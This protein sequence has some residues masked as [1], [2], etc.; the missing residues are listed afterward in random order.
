MLAGVRGDKV[1][2]AGN[3]GG[4]G[5]SADVIFASKQFTSCFFYVISSEFIIIL[6]SGDSR[7]A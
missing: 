1:D 2:I 7:N 5:V 3:S 6:Q 4:L